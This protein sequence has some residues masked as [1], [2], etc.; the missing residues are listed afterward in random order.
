MN[1][2]L[3]QFLIEHGADITAVDNTGKTPLELAIEKG[4]YF[5]SLFFFFEENGKIFNDTF[6]TKKNISIHNREMLI[7]NCSNQRCHQNFKRNE[8]K[9]P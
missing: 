3:T 4:N 6:E 5:E 7:I 1:A 8:A 2:K 9:T